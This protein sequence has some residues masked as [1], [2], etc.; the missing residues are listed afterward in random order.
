MANAPGIR[1]VESDSVVAVSPAGA[2]LT[3]MV[4][5]STRGRIDR[6]QLVRNWQQ[7]VERYGSFGDSYDLSFAMWDYIKNGGSEARILRMVGADAAQAVTP[8][9]DGANVNAVT[10]ANLATSVARIYAA[11]PGAWGDTLS[12]SF[13]RKKATVGTAAQVTTNASGQNLPRPAATAASKALSRQALLSV[14]DVQVGDVL[15]PYDGV[16]GA[17]IGSDPITVLQVEPSTRSIKYVTPGSAIPANAVCKSASRHLATV[18]ATGQLETG[19][20][21]L[22]VESVD[23]LERGSLVSIIHCSDYDNDGLILSSRAEHVDAVIEKIV[24]R[25]LHFAA[26]VTLTPDSNGNRPALP[27]SAPAKDLIADAGAGVLGANAALDLTITAAS[28]GAAGNT[29][30]VSLQAG[31]A[32]EVSVTGRTVTITIVNGTA[33]SAVVALVAAD[34]TASALIALAHTGNGAQTITMPATLTRSLKGGADTIVVSQE[35]DLQIK[36]DGVEVESSRHQ[37]L[38]FQTTSSNYIG[39]RLGGSLS[40]DFGFRIPSDSSQS[41]RIIADSITAATS[42]AQLPRSAEDLSLSGGLDG[43]VPTDTAIRGTAAPRT[44]LYILDDHDDIDMLVVPNFSSGFLQ[45]GVI[46]YVE[47]RADMIALLDMPADLTSAEDMAA[48]RSQTLG[49]SSSFAALYAPYGKIVDPRK[50]VPR[51]SLFQVP[52]TPAVAALMASRAD[53]SG[54][55]VP[56]ANQQLGWAGLLINVTEAEHGALNDL[57]IN[58]IKL[59]KRSGI[60][61][62]GARTLSNS[63]DGRKFT[64]V[65]RFLNFMKQSIGR[66]LTSFIFKPANSALFGDISNSIER[67]LSDQWSAGALF[68]QDRR[69][70]AYFVKCDAETTSQTDLANGVVNCVIGVSPVT[71]AEQIIFQINVSAG[72]VRVDEQ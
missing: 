68:P 54:V 32:N 56:A 31:G 10:T 1:F 24:G 71:P 28:P 50:G 20:Q 53:S 12:V 49:S 39:T 72:G 67:F 17:L 22:T 43:A 27:A 21:T 2:S 19:G 18:K 60:R 70:S 44:G 55:H 45:Q 26:A 9:A 33:A 37:G 61:L 38:S 59:V 35:V 51:G 42:V 25:T 14:R 23:G 66:D 40:A 46:D 11:D 34:A 30:N 4:G 5:Q 63:A 69:S 16:T 47:G 36:E 58:I 13:F 6:A 41:L 8:A 65:R 62:Y 29:I 57:G 7:Y 64:N 3:A 15:T 52:P 48:H